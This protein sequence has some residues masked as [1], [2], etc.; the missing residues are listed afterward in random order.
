MILQPARKDRGQALVV[1][2][3]AS[4]DADSGADSNSDASSTASA[5]Q[6]P[7]AP[8]RNRH[9]GHSSTPNRSRQQPNPHNT[10]YTAA[11][12]EHLAT[13]MADRCPDIETGGRT[14][15]SMYKALL[16]KS[17]THPTDYGWAAGRSEGA[18]MGRCRKKR[19]WFDKRN[20][21]I[22]REKTHRG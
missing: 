12:D 10:V 13:F 15:P 20:A 11:D 18:W 6:Y 4:T 21:R 19:D 5:S 22:R 1:T 3:S 9:A 2:R 17:R 7:Y 16:D 8:F 14:A